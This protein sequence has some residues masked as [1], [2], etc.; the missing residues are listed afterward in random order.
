MAN[1]PWAKFS[2]L[3]GPTETNVCTYYNVHP[4]PADSEEP[5]PIGRPCANVEALIVDAEEQP[6]KLGDVGELLIRG[7]VVMRG[8]WGQPEMTDRGFYRQKTHQYLDNVYYRTGDLVQSDGRGDL[9][10]LGRKD[11]QIKTRGYRVEL[12]EIEV[13]LL[14][15][16]MVE[17]AAA[18]PVPDGEGS[19]LIEAAVVAKDSNSID[20]TELRD[21]LGS[22]LPPYAVP[23]N[24]KLMAK[25]PR[26]STGKINRRELQAISTASKQ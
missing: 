2:N 7:G 12:D 13:A 14:A 8:F 23:V 21:H 18:Y 26:T 25:F 17:E 22:K 4:I 15:Y 9:K 11:R 19:N 20:M 16:E 3:Y 6:V 5:I 10:F 24:I 1:L